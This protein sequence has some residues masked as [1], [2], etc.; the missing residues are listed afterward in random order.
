MR[1]TL[2]IL[3]GLAVVAAAVGPAQADR[4]RQRRDQAD[5]VL[6]GAVQAV[7]A[8]DTK[9]YRADVIESKV[10]E[11]E[12]GTGLN[13]GDTFRAY[14]YR[15]KAGMGGLEFD[16]AGHKA[17]AATGVVGPTAEPTTRIPVFRADHPFIF[18]IRDRH[19]GV[20]L[21]PGRFAAPK[22]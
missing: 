1:R 2:F 3:A 14:C 5:Y 4:P 19:S 16:T 11:V 7:Y 6:G 13:R 10:E 9:G 18:L 12:K 20:I 22:A 21:F 8:R 17:A 15:R